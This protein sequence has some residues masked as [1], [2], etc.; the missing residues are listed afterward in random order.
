MF[1]W[2]NIFVADAA[3]K[4]NKSLE[5]MTIAELAR[6]QGKHPVDAL[7]DL[8]VRED[9]KTEFAMPG[10]TNAAIDMRN[11]GASTHPGGFIRRRSAYQIPDLR[12]LPHALPGP[13]GPGQTGDVGSKRLIG[14]FPR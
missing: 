3:L 14:G 9:L 8:A 6:Q 5:G 13:P 11:A 12:P 2:D 4:A 10:F 1:R 7:L